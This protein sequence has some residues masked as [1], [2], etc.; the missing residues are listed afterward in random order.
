M[1]DL[2][3]GA[4]CLK[5]LLFIFN[6]VF[7][8]CGGALM[9]ISIW[10]V[11]DPEMSSYTNIVNNPL[12]TAAMY[13][14]L[15]VG[16]FIFL[17]G[18]LGCCGACKESA[19]MLS[20]YA[21]LIA[22]ILILQVVGAILA[23][24]FHDS[25]EEELQEEMTDQVYNYVTNDENDATT[26][27]WNILQFEM[28]CCGAT[29]YE[30]YVDSK[31]QNMTKDP[32]PDSCCVQKASA[33]WDNIQPEDRDKCLEEAR[34]GPATFTFLNAEGCYTSLKEWM[35]ANALILVGVGFGLAFVQV[36]GIV[37][38]CCVKKEINKSS[39]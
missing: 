15:A 18:F 4:T 21:F 22:V 14:I 37:F 39:Y 29:G 8:V 23:V 38:A 27:A 2:S 16:V 11:V 1:A 5:Y 7:F 35:S 30:D 36:F 9:G 25:L 34:T 13:L 6:F 20:T 3:C 32:V 19:C 26:K 28:K 10:L 31:F 12:I 17:I 33:D 24:V